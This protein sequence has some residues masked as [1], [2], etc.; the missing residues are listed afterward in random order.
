VIFRRYL[1][2]AVIV[3]LA[4]ALR[5]GFIL[6]RTDSVAA[7]SE[8]PDQ[9]E[10]LQIGR[11]LSTGDGLQFTDPRFGQEVWAYRTP[12]YPL[13]VAVCGGRLALIRLTQALLD[14]STII[15]VY[16]LARNWLGEGTSLLAAALAAVNPLS[17]Y[18]SGMILSESLFT[19]MLIWGMVLMTRRAWFA[20]TILLAMSVLVR[21]SAL[22]LPAILSMFAR[23]KSPTES[24]FSRRTR[25]HRRGAALLSQCIRIGAAAIL[26][27]LV[28]LPW[29]WRNHQ[30]LGEWIWTST[31]S[32]V[33]QYDGFHPG[34]TGASDQDFLRDMP[35]LAAMTEVQRSNYLGEKAREFIQS[36]PL[37]CLKLAVLKIARLW[38]PMPLS[39][40]YSR[41]VYVAVE[42]AYALP[43]FIFAIVGLM[44][45]GWRSHIGDEWHSTPTLTLPLSTRGGDNEVDSMPHA[46][47]L[48]RNGW[49][50]G[51]R[52]FLLAPALY[53]T[54]IH[55]ASVAS[56]R[57]RAPLEP[58]LA[59]P[60]AFA[61]A[62]R[63]GMDSESFGAK[64]PA[65]V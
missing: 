62:P 27:A 50:S 25:W 43:L 49:R 39:A 20:G 58:L 33:T 64:M 29:A 15:A 32:G 13:L 19:A 21:P 42:L 26:T 2:L 54:L 63:R 4:L 6:T 24:P 30:L 9:T 22:A 3:Q 7:L 59:I 51:A 52:R 5:L 10:Y 48:P 55:A 37:E 8:L 45:N 41:P 47:G 18:F 46:L 38:S 28:L 35:E 61:I 11:N 60:A 34:A 12:G 56:L 36:H 53:F 57:Y 23:G 14:T 31:N 65:D 44:R 1:A 17:I 40:Q 16:L